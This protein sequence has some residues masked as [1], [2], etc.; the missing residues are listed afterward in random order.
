MSDLKD[1]NSRPLQIAVE[2]KILPLID[3]LYPLSRPKKALKALQ[4]RWTGRP[5]QWEELKRR[6]AQDQ[7]RRI[8]RKVQ[9]WGKWVDAKKL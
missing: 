2:R 6:L 8:E 3:V 5:E 7:R 1:N 9:R 4:R